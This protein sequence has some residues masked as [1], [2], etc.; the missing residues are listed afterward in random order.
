MTLFRRWVRACGTIS[1]TLNILNINTLSY[2]A[3]VSEGTPQMHISLTV[4]SLSVPK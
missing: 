1:G 2:Y 4:N 3:L